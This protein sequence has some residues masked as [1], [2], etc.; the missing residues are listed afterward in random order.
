VEEKVAG[1]PESEGSF[2][3]V[4]VVGA[5]IVGDVDLDDGVGFRKKE[6]LRV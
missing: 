3:V 5:G 6:K 2:V 1:Y 4:V